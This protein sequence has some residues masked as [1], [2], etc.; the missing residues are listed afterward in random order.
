VADFNGD[1][2][3]DLVWQDP[4]TGTSQVWFMGG[5]PGTTVIGSAGLSG[6][7]TWRIVGA[8]DLNGDGHPDL[9]WQ[10]PATG[11][12]QVW[13]M[14]GA[15]GTTFDGAAAISGPNAWRIV[16]VAD[17]NGDGHPDLIWQD[18]ATGMSQVWLMSGAQGTTRI[19]A[20]DLSKGNAWRIA[21]AAD[22]DGNGRP[23]IIWQDPVT[24]MAQVWSMGGTHGTTLIGTATLSGSTS[25]R[26]AR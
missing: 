20:P 6:S 21:G 13:Y 14:G 2:H 4:A 1:G 15:Q 11:T 16:G 12:S 22:F 25:W 10:D 9:I 18:P 5:T 8:A 7:S 19:G 26:I 23:E 3:P 24:G 17:F